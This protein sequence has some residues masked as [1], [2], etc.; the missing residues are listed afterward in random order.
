M[1]EIGGRRKEEGAVIVIGAAA[2]QFLPAVIQF[3][4]AAGERR[5]KKA[6]IIISRLIIE[7]EEIIG[8]RIGF[9][10]L[11]GLDHDDAALR[12]LGKATGDDAAG[13]TA[14]KDEVVADFGHIASR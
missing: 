14:A 10:R 9:I 8:G 4:R 5:S 11:A 1:I 7:E 6:P 3:G 13:G 2:E 12:L